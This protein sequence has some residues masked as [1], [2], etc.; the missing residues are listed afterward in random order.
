MLKKLRLV[1]DPE[2]SNTIYLCVGRFRLIFWRGMCLGWYN[3]EL[4]RVLR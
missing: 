3:S 2:D 1:Q 4:N